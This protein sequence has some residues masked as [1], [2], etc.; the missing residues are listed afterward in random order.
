MSINI[1]DNDHDII[2]KLS[3]GKIIAMPMDTIYGFCAS[4]KHHD[5]IV[6]LFRIKKRPYDKP[7]IILVEDTEKAKRIWDSDIPEE[8][9][10]AMNK[11]W[12]GDCT[13]I[14]DA[15]NSYELHEGICSIDGQVA[16]RVPKDSRIKNII[17]SVGPLV[18]TSVNVTN[19]APA[20]DFDDAVRMFG[21][22]H[23]VCFVKGESTKDEPSSV[24]RFFKDGKFKVL[25]KN[26]YNF[27]GLF[28]A[29][30]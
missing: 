20:F 24:V 22:E 18:S 15:R 28:H 26:Q 16:I 27:A 25:R 19:H 8:M 17:K 3:R 29:E 30:G 23:R 12:P 11:L 13:F 4:I 21:G 7:M 9:E 10:V 14:F 1:L 6:E 2:D 5:A